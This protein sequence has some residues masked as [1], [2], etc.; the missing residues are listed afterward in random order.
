MRIINK[1]NKRI[2]VYNDY[3]IIGNKI[4]F[5]FRYHIKGEKDIFVIRGTKNEKSKL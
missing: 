5:G 2:Y 3:K 4:L 1:N